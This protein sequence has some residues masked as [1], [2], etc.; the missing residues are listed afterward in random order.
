LLL[1]YEL[2]Y[3]FYDGCSKSNA[4]CCQPTTS[5]A[6]VGGM[7]VEVEPSWQYSVTFC[8][9]VSDR[10]SD[11]IASDMEVHMKQGCAIES[12]HVEN[13]EHIDLHWRFLNV[14]GD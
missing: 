11:K 14:Y 8:H 3:I 4:S 2:Y 6:D 9:P 7:T 10:Q 12:I 1:I 13:M 5:E